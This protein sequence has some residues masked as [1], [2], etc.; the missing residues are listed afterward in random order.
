M[1]TIKTFILAVSLI[2]SAAWADTVNINTASKNE[3]MSLKGVGESRA[4]AIIK[5][6]K[7]HKFRSVAE[8][9]DVSGIGE[10][11]YKDNKKQIKISGK[12]TLSET[13]PKAKKSEEKADKGS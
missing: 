3:L 1:K 11:I 2:M 8:I 7:K 12:T 5:Y 13:A 6:R 4:E 10:E 9:K